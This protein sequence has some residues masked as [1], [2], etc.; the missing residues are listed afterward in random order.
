[1]KCDNC[2]NEIIQ[3]PDIAHAGLCKKCRDHVISEIEAEH[4][5]FAEER[6]S[7]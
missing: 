2:P 5:E 3:E 7:E 4:P 1:M 6:R